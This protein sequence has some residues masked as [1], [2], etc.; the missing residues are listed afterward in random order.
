MRPLALTLFSAAIFASLTGCSSKAERKFDLEED[1]NERRAS[2]SGSSP[3]VDPLQAHLA[4]V[5]ARLSAEAPPAPSAP[6]VPPPPLP[7]PNR[8]GIKGPA[9]SPDPHVARQ[10]ALVD[11]AEFGGP[12]TPLPPGVGIAPAT[13]TS[14]PATKVHAS[15]VSAS[16]SLPP[17]V[18]Q[19][20]VRR[21]F[22]RLRLCYEN[23]L[24][25]DPKLEGRVD[26]A[27]VIGLDGSVGSVAT[28]GTMPNADVNTCVARMFASM[29][30]PAPDGGVVKVKYPIAFSPGESPPASTPA[31]PSSIATVAGMSK[32]TLTEVTKAL[33]DAGCSD[34]QL[35]S[36]TAN[37]GTTWVV[38]KDGRSFTVTFASAID[39]K[40]DDALVRD[41][42]AKGAVRRGGASEGNFLFAVVADDGDKA[43]AKALL[44]AILP[45]P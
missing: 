41:L 12:P 27:F 42:E 45:P 33:I 32:A 24:R 19:R 21:E 28:S 4:E 30:F 6:P 39:P 36:S 34:V 16:G 13:G 5:A 44:D 26:T 29:T 7:R 2:K 10:A 9:N 23:A 15:G 17:E 38:K 31:T 35:K 20:V 40:L 14:K 18:I 25:S 1:P 3:D 22:S 37:E 8:Y 43:A 11:A